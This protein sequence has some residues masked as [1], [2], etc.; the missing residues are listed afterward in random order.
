[1][2]E[3]A[4]GDDTDWLFCEQIRSVGL[5]L[6]KEEETLLAWGY[7]SYWPRQGFAYAIPCGR[8]TP[9]PKPLSPVDTHGQN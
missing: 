1:M 4:T 3:R 2:D 8:R 6:D 5:F 7:A 9:M